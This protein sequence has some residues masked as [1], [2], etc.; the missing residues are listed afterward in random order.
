MKY[1]NGMEDI[2]L[3]RNMRDRVDRLDQTLQQ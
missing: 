1:R 2:H 3:L